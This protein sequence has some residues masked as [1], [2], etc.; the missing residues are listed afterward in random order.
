[1]E[2]IEAVLFDLGN[3]LVN[4]DLKRFE[5]AIKP[6]GY[7]GIDNINDFITKSDICVKYMKGS[8]TSA[9]FFNKVKNILDIE[10]DMKSFYEAWNSI[11]YPSKEMEAIVRI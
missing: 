6:Y 7:K 3:V 5:K 11:F 8:L 4:F 2:R 1:M 9:V 10:I